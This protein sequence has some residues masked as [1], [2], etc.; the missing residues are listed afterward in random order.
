MREGGLTAVSEWSLDRDPLFR[1]WMGAEVFLGRSPPL[2]APLFAFEAPVIPES[3]AVTLSVR[4]W[5]LRT[6]AVVVA[7]AGGIVWFAFGSQAASMGVAKQFLQVIQYVGPCVIPP[8][9]PVTAEYP[10][11]LS[12]EFWLANGRRPSVPIRM[13]VDDDS[14]EVAF[15]N[16]FG[17][18]A[19]S[20]LPWHGLVFLRGVL[21][22][23]ARA[24]GFAA[25]RGPVRRQRSSV[26]EVVS[27]TGRVWWVGVPYLTVEGW[28]CDAGV[29][30]VELAC[31]RAGTAFVALARACVGLSQ[32]RVLLCDMDGEDVR[33]ESALVFPASEFVLSES[34]GGIPVELRILPD[35]DGR[36]ELWM[37]VGGE[38]NTARM[39]GDPIAVLLWMM[40]WALDAL[41]NRGSP[42]GR[43]AHDPLLC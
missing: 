6:G 13:W 28:E 11:R 15:E 4:V 29:E 23:A 33:A 42:P 17:V 37:A 12:V 8:L 20:S 5:V 14:G 7:A 32:A 10:L 9:R 31:A 25:R 30:G 22:P 21:G 27:H 18:R 43:E 35:A 26:I 41:A 1:R 39:A 2:Q 19:L 38:V 24:V 40:R 3:V 36:G 16:R 34:V